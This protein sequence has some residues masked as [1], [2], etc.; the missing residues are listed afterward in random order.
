MN[1]ERDNETTGE[2]LFMEELGQIHGGT[3]PLG[4]VPVTLA[5]YEVEVGVKEPV[6]PPPVTTQLL[7]EAGP[8]PPPYMTQA[9][10]ETGPTLPP[11]RL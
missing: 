8:T 2:E 3:R 4:P 1:Q 11:P 9:L 5:R 7:R 6:F 10:N